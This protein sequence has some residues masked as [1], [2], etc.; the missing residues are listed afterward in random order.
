VRAGTLLVKEQNKTSFEVFS[1]FPILEGVTNK[2]R[3]VKKHTWGNGIEG[4]VA[5]RPLDDDELPIS[6]FAPYFFRDNTAFASKMEMD[7]CLAG[8]ALSCEKATQDGVEITEGP[9]YEE[10]LE[11]FLNEHPSKSKT[12]FPSAFVSFKGSTIFVPRQYIPEFEFR[13]PVID[14]QTVS[15]LDRKIYKL[16]VPIMGYEETAIFCNIY[17]PEHIFDGY[18]PRE[19]DD[20]QGVLWMNGYSA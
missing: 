17:V 8:L 6:F 18:I 5:A 20:I 16:F 7:I 12:D 15:F 3:I 19:G 11:K 14:I 4:V 1:C 9:L 2:L 10:Q 13:C